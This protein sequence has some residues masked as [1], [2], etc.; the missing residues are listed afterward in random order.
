MRQRRAFSWLLT[1]AMTCRGVATDLRVQGI[2]AALVGCEAGDLT[3]EER[4]TVEAIA[5]NPGHRFVAWLNLRIYELNRLLGLV[6]S[7]RT[8]E[9]EIAAEANPESDGNPWW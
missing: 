5:R 8:D 1:R 4:A 2:D 9:P 7:P 6:P 3:A